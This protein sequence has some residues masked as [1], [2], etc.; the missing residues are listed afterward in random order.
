MSQVRTLAEKPRVPPLADGDRLTR[1]EFERRYEAMTHLNRAEL[2]DGVVYMPSPVRIEN[3]GEPHMS[4]VG[5]LCFY[6]SQTPG[7]RGGDNSSVR[8][9]VD[10]ERQ[11]DGVLFVPGEG[12]LVDVDGYI[13]GSPDLVAEISASS[14]RID[15]GTK[16]Q[17]FRRNGVKEYLVWR[18]DDRAIDWFI[19]RD[20]QYDRLAAHEGLLKSVAFP[21][22]WLD[23]D[24]LV[25][26][27][28]ARAFEVLQQG[29][30]S[31]EHAA[32]VAVLQAK[33]Q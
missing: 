15:L 29:L 5:L 33:R 7:V 17:A 4:I 12:A 32:F 14:A 30:R 18:V 19:L 3:H 23:P 10:N 6:R 31:P 21:G 13:A 20:G 25:R 1:A 24:A 27:D 16:M 8:L 11:P 9:D 22:L 28:L 2:I 26:G